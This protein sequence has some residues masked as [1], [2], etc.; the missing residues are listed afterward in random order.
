MT[1]N[2]S[3]ANKKNLSYAWLLIVV[4][5]VFSCTIV[6]SKPSIVRV[7]IRRGFRGREPLGGWVAKDRA[8]KARAEA[9]VGLESIPLETP[10]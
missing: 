5:C 7:Y 1:E 2:L 8:C 10:N 9:W 3:S 4:T 6:P